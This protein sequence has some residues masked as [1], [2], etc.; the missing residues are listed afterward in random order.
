MNTRQRPDGV[1]GQFYWHAL[2]L[3]SL[4]LS[5]PLLETIR[6]QPEFL[7]AHSLSGWSLFV[8]IVGV[9]FA[10]ELILLAAVYLLTRAFKPAER[11]IKSGV[12]FILFGLLAFIQIDLWMNFSLPVAAA[13]SCLSAAVALK[14]YTASLYIRTFLTVATF[15]VVITPAAFCLDANIRQ[16]LLPEKTVTTLAANEPAGNHPVV[17]ILLDELPI[18]SL[19]D[20]AG[21]INADRFPNLAAFALQ[22]TWYKYATT[23]AEATLIAVP[24]LLTGQTIKP[25]NKKL[26]LAANYPQNLFTLLSGTHAVNAFE[27]FTHLCPESLCNAPDPD[28]QIIAEDTLVVFLHKVAPDPYRQKLPQID[29]KWFGYLRDET[30]RRNVHTD[31]NLHP[32]HRYKVRL[33]KFSQFLSALET[34]ESN[35]LNYLHILLPH[36]PWMY[37]PDGREYA[38]AEQRSFTG[39]LPE[40]ASG[41]QRKHQLYPQQ[42]LMDFIQQRHLLQAGFTDQLIGEI[43]AQLRKRGMFDNAM[44]IVMGDHGVSFSAGE[45]LRE[46]SD[47]N[48]QDVLSVPLFIKYPGQKKGELNQ[49]AARTID[50]LPT[51][52]DSLGI[53]STGQELDGVSLL[54]SAFTGPATL[55]IQRDTGKI[56]PYDFAHFKQRIDLAVRERRTEMSNGDFSALYLINGETLVNR[57][58][59]DLSITEPVEY[60]IKLDNPHLY[61]NIDPDANSI[62]SLIR[63]NRMGGAN[64][65]HK[66]S[67]AVAVNGTIRAVSVLEAV[68]TV[69]FDYQVLVAPE[70]FRNGENSIRFFEVTNGGAELLLA[71]IARYQDRQAKL[72][73]LEDET[74][75]LEVDA[76][77]LPISR[78]GNGGSLTIHVN[79]DSDQVRLDGWAAETSSGQVASEIFFFFDHQLVSSVT[80][81]LKSPQAQE[82]TGFER[83]AS[84]G[85]SLTIPMPLEPGQDPL[86]FSAIA[87]FEDP[88]ASP[89]A[90]E[91]RYNNTATAVLTTRLI[92]SGKDVLGSDRPKDS[93][94]LGRVYNFSDDEQAEL[95]AGSGWSRV[96]SGGAR[97]NT[98]TEASLKFKVAD[99]SNALQIIVQS[100]PFFVE[101]KLEKQGVDVILSS[102]N[103]QRLELTRGVSDGEFRIQISPEDISPDGTVTLVLKFPDAASPSSLG[104][105]ND[106]RPLALRVK[107]IQVLVAH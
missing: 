71:P 91:L 29:N 73:N 79:L 22:S 69:P 104:V 27:T 17:L 86:P 23:V 50:V 52:L 90:H 30:E 40:G 53:R 43:F 70:S 4:L 20:S 60:T 84:A 39:T 65:F 103:R 93:I 21:N 2:L 57:K 10:L 72:L 3:S 45:S 66:S 95:L 41:Q 88:D 42:H 14:L 31:L 89:S 58:T 48:F 34:I 37:L 96:S 24:P 36:S 8:W 59:E 49:Q 85:F 56:L 107:T 99:N 82:Y 76:V 97:W 15:L 98:T 16:M 9:S 63:A 32:H 25:D 46:A 106:E 19:L 68:E 92:H 87:V 67:V 13:L 54:D 11:W 35:S 83:S 74:S 47:A 44:V 78:S 1:F 101:G 55:N 105:N 7:L 77:Q 64:G 18:V 38:R 80:P 81:A 26:A 62:P 94:I 5:Q 61:T 100:S 102:G 51:I 12:L 6:S 28:W 75:Y 33:Q